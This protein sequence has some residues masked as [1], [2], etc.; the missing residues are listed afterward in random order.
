[1]FIIVLW[2]IFAALVG[3]YASGKGRSGFGFF[4][5]SLIISPLICFIILLV[6]GD[7]NGAQ[8]VGKVISAPVKKC[9]KCAERILLEANFCKHCSSDLTIE[10]IAEE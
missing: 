10:N 7:K 3:G 8:S 4:L 1:M 5:L 9:P 6:I 2:L